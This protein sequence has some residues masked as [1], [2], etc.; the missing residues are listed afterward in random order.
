MTTVRASC[1]NDGVSSVSTPASFWLD[2]PGLRKLREK[3]G[4][5]AQA[6]A[7]LLGVHRTTVCRWESGEIAIPKPAQI[8]S[9]W[10]LRTQK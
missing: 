4:I 6:L 2:G 5:S 9:A 8:S 10:L 7:D 3:A 1:Y